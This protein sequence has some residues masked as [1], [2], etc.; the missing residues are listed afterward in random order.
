MAIINEATSLEDLQA[1][2]LEHFKDLDLEKMKEMMAR[3]F[4]IANLLGRV[5][6]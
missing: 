1:K 3:S 2:I 6:V 5:S 4:F